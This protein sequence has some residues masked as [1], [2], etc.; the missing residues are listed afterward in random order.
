VCLSRGSSAVGVKVY[1]NGMLISEKSTSL[2]R[3]GDSQYVLDLIRRNGTFSV[4]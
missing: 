2:G 3:R 4:P 1:V